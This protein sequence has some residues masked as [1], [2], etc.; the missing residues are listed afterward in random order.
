MKNSG[1]STSQS[2]YFRKSNS[3]SLLVAKHSPFPGVHQTQPWLGDKVQATALA[4][5]RTNTSTTALAVRGSKIEH[6]V[7]CSC[8]VEI[9]YHNPR[10][11][12]PRAR[13]KTMPLIKSI[14]ERALHHS[15][16]LAKNNVRAHCSREHATRA[17]SDRNKDCS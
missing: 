16:S 11:L 12:I 8:S 9:E 14:Q 4:V 6:A 5:Q 7:N 15:P 10:G 1:L 2:G 13:A 3:S 17:Q